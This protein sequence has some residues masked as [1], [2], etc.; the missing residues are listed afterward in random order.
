MPARIC[1][2][3]ANGNRFLT[4]FVPFSSV[5]HRVNVIFV[6]EVLVF[7]MIYVND[8]HLLSIHVVTAWFPYSRKVHKGC[9]R[10]CRNHCHRHAA[11][12]STFMETTSPGTAGSHNHHSFSTVMAWKE[13]NHFN[14]SQSL[15]HLQP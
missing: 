11:T 15:R 5:W 8:A 9:R 12:I 10:H 3:H 1:R 2:F 4:I 13:L 6:D 7:A 14:F